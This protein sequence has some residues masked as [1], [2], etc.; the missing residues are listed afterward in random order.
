VLGRPYCLGKDYFDLGL[1][2][3]GMVVSPLAK[4]FEDCGVNVVDDEVRHFSFCP[5][6]K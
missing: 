1:N 4:K 6:E 5:F 3:T 2:C